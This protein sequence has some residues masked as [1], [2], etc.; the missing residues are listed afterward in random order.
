VNQKEVALEF[1]FKNTTG[2]SLEIS[3][4]QTSC[5]CT[6]AKVDSK[7]IPAGGTGSVHVQF[8]SGG[9]R[10]EQVKSVEVRTSDREMQML[11]LR[12][13]VQETISFSQKEFLWSAGSAP[14]A[15]DSIMEVD[16]SSGATILGA[17]S[18]NDQFDVKL[19]EL[20]PGRRYRLSVTPRSTEVPV[21]S[22]VK[23]QLTDPKKR[24]IFLQTRV[25]N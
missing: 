22:S 23:I 9:R 15:Q 3:S 4:I 13:V 14:V 10:G 17:E 25:E 11:V 12:V 5:G 19:Q 24:S 8:H 18:L 16:P 6:A 1:P 21:T 20:D 7:E 2:A